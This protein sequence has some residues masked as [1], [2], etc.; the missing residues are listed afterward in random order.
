[1]PPKELAEL[2]TQLQELLNKGYI[3]PSSSPWGC[4]ALFGKKKGDSLRLCVD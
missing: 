2:K 1:M 4:P 3:H